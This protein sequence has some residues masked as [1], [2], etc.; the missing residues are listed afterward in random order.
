MANV[1]VTTEKQCMKGLD[2]S[3]QR[4][5]F[6]GAQRKAT[7]FSVEGMKALNSKSEN[8]GKIHMCR[9]LSLPVYMENNG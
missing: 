3:A 1:R 2:C 5:V 7:G 8:S 6:Q 9:R 4:E